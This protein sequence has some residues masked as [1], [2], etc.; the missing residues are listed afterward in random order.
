[1]V[2]WSFPG[3]RGSGELLSRLPNLKAPYTAALGAA[4]RQDSGRGAALVPLWCCWRPRR[5]ARGPPGSAWGLGSQ[6][7]ERGTAYRYGESIKQQNAVD[8]RP[9]TP[10]AR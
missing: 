9:Q 4:E 3:P 6:P 5:G 7:G 8:T 2:D 10:P 1:M